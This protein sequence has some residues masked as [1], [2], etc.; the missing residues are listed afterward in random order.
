MI[1]LFIRRSQSAKVPCRGFAAPRKL[2]A[3]LGLTLS[4]YHSRR[5]VPA[6]ERL[7]DVPI[8]PL[9]QRT[10]PNHGTSD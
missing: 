2:N 6:N 10:H 1:D 4:G 8:E 7:S 5:N 3:A 9:A